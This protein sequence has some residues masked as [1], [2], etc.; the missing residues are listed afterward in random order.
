MNKQTT[1]AIAR[2]ICPKLAYKILDTLTLTMPRHYTLKDIEIIIGIE[3]EKA[4]EK[5]YEAVQEAN[6]RAEALMEALKET[7]ECIEELR[8]LFQHQS[9]EIKKRWPQAD[10]DKWKAL[11][12]HGAA[13]PKTEG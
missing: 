8:T 3:M 13:A 4:L 7:I 12:A 10:I 9:G 11:A 1:A 2:E 5:A 6:T